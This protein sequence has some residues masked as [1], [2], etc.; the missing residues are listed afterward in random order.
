MILNGEEV[1]N[2][3]IDQETIELPSEFDSLAK[4]QD[5][6]GFYAYEDVDPIDIDTFSIYS[7][8]M[9]TDVAK[10]RWVWGQA[11]A[12][13]E[14]TNSS[15]NSITAFNDYAFANY[16]AN[17]NYPDF[18]NWKQAFFSNVEAESKTLRLP[19]YQLPRF[20]IGTEL[21]TQ[22]YDD[23]Q[24]ITSSLSDND[25]VANRKYLTLNPN[26]D[27]DSDTCLLYTSDAADE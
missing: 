24:D 11:V 8:S 9:P 22:L 6:L 20:E 14:Q 10:R 27:W 3:D 12:S 19:S 25:D 4:S 23:I 5:W 15:I 17:Y 26:E 2:L 1:I 13:P 7:Y 16:A 18:A 21:T